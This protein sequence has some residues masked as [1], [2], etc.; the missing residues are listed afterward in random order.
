MLMNIS[1]CFLLDGLVK[2]PIRIALYQNV[3][4]QVDFIN[5]ILPE[6]FPMH[7]SHIFLLSVILC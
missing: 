3:F 5:L 6:I 1:T 7:F 2:M 4:V